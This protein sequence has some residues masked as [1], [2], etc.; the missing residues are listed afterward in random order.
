MYIL[1]VD[2]KAVQENQT[3]S[4]VVQANIS[5]LIIMRLDGRHGAMGRDRARRGAPTMLRR[6]R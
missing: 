2:C 1:Q 4:R 5:P 3:S 6:T